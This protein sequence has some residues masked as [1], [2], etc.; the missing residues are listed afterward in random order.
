VEVAREDGEARLDGK[1]R[2][3]QHQLE[4]QQRVVIQFSEASQLL[5]V[6]LA[7]LEQE[8]VEVAD[9]VAVRVMTRVNL[10]LPLLDHK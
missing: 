3:G 4:M 10:P 2:Q 8:R 7:D 6:D 9:Q 5:V 1:E